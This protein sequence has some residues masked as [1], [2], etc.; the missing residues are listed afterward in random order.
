MTIYI[1]MS[2]FNTIFASFSFFLNPLNSTKFYRQIF[3]KVRPARS[4]GVK[5]ACHQA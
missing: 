3:L 2:E 1:L 4:S 5:G